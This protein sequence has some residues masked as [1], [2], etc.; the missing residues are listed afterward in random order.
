MP[1]AQTAIKV[2]RIDNLETAD[3]I[4]ERRRQISRSLIPVGRCLVINIPRR[5]QTA[6]SR[7]ELEDARSNYLALALNT[8]PKC[9]GSGVKLGLRIEP[10]GCVSR[11]L[12]NQLL[13][14]D[15]LIGNQQ[16]TVSSCVPTVVSRGSDSRFCWSRKNEEF[17]ADFYLLAKRT[18]D[19]KDFSIFRLHCLAGCNWKHCVE[20]LNMNRGDFFHAVYRIQETVGEAAVELRPHAIYPLSEYFGRC[21]P[22]IIGDR[23]IQETIRKPAVGLRPA[24]SLYRKYRA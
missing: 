14:R 22:H 24:L 23:R 8:C 1:A 19:P 12:Y 6:Q 11:N 9:C 4:R 17:S 18:L 7:E 21:S 15:L 10:C 13:S 3:E 5:F 16:M 20:V 2:V